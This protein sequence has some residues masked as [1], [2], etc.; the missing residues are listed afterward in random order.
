VRILLLSQWYPP[1]PDIRIESLASGLFE[2]GHQ[3]TVI[4]GFPNYPH[5]R[6]YPG[7]KQRLWQ[8]EIKD[9]IHIIRFPLYPDH[10]RSAIRRALTYLSFT[11]SAFLL[12][13]IFSGK[14]DVLWVYH[15]P[16]TIGIPAL[17]ISLL[18]RIPF[19]YEI[20][21]MWPETVIASGMLNS[22]LPLKMLSLLARFIY[23]RAAAIT[24]IS[25]GFK[26]NLEGKGVP[27]NKISVIPNWADE[28]IYRPVERNPSLGEKY[29]LVNRFNIIFAG[30]MG[31]A[32]GLT[33]VI[34]AAEFLADVPDIQFIF[35]GDGID[36]QSLKAI[37]K[38]KHLN[39]VQFVDRQPSE[40]MPYLFAWGDVLLV[41][42]R[43]D[44]LFHMTIP[45]KTLAYMACGRFIICAVPGDGAEIIQ[46]AG[47]GLICRPND[48]EGL[49]DAVR[50][51][52][53]MP[54][55]KREAMGMAGRQVFLDQ[56]TREKLINKYEAV[57]QSVTKRV[58]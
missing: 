14:A 50:Q 3:V 4:T 46:Q 49:A 40:Q 23:R 5:G 38:E 29:Q 21:D 58:N 7:Y 35:I 13:P 10:S 32:Q 16:L 45:S 57:F 52:Y 44:P 25:R 22:S 30:T 53:A 54:A 41:Q 2:N 11:L 36:L 9:G 47:A 24:V 19:V 43:D 12:G 26:A 55:T 1:E 42:L 17:W 48:P 34:S 8:H 6:I 18:R 56:F 37:S 20:Q 15:P 28:K 31:P 39:N 33:T 51:A 27:I